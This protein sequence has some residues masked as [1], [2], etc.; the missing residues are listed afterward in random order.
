M[1]AAQIEKLTPQ[2]Q[3]DLALG[4]L[5]PELGAGQFVDEV[6]LRARE[7]GQGDV[8][9]Q[10]RRAVAL[11]P[12]VVGLGGLDQIEAV[13]EAGAAAAVHRHAQ[14]QRRGPRRADGA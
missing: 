1:D 2:P 10:G 9:H 14:H 6:D 12:Q 5:H 13:L 4:L 8:V 3:L 11:D 7:Q